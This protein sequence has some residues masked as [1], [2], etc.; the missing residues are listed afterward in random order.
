MK[1]KL[2]NDETVIRTAD[3]ASI[4]NDPAN[5]H[6]VEYQAW[7]AEGNTPDPADPVPPPPVD[8]L[9][10]EELFDMLKAKGVLA[11]VDRP[12]PRP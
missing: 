9:A 5:R 4:P 10:A 3:G 12:R 2:T 1:Y 8:P 7:L 11:D 6:W